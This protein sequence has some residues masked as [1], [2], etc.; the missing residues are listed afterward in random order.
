MTKLIIK[1]G[2][3]Y[4]FFAYDEK[5]VEKAKSIPGASWSK[6]E[7]CWKYPLTKMTYYNLKKEFDIYHEEVEM[8]I[9]KVTFEL[10]KYKF[11]TKPYKHQIDAISFILGQFGVNV[12]KDGI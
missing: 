2:A 11:K 3:F 12:I 8:S 9:K 4:L 6:L 1:N 5:L 7:R 10:K